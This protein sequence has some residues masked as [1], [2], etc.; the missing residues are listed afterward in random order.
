MLSMNGA[1]GAKGQ[2]FA[3]VAVQH[4]DAAGFDHRF[5]IGELFAA[6]GRAGELD[7]NG[8]DKIVCRRVPVPVVPERLGEIYVNIAVGGKFSGAR[9]CRLGKVKRRH[10]QAKLGHVDR[11]SPF[12]VSDAQPA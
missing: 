3:R 2:L 4:Q 9:N 5:N 8:G 6:L 1:A 7:E 11:I 10:V 12:A